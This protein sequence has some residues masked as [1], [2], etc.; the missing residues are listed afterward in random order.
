MGK[1][2]TRG[3]EENAMSKPERKRP[4]TV[5]VQILYE[6]SRL[7]QDCLHQ[8]YLSLVPVTRRR[9]SPTV[10]QKESATPVEERQTS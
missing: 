6:P 1:V 7:A 8:A 5:E 4:L 9:I 2:P 3:I 10:T